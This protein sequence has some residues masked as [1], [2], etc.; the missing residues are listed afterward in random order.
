MPLKTLKALPRDADAGVFPIDLSD[1][2][3]DGAVF[4]FRSP[5]AADLFP[6]NNIIKELKIGYTEYPDLLIYQIYIMGRCYLPDQDDDGEN[7]YRSF[8]DLGRANAGVFY[9][10]LT[11]FMAASPLDILD[12]KI[13]EAKNVSA[14]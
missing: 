7:P 13:A 8:A 2:A 3:G 14:E 12:G 9:R 10:L 1:V 5:K 4:R 11:E 6:D